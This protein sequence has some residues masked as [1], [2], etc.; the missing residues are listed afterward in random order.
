MYILNSAND[1]LINADFAERF[2]VA[3]KPDAALVIASYSDT[4]PPVTV[5]RY[6]D[7]EEA[8]AVLFEIMQALAGEQRYYTMPESRR[9]H[10]ERVIKDARTKRRGG[11]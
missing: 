8:R 5:G 11:S 3:E 9:Y 2:C 1:Q 7:A 4:R 6:K 10:G